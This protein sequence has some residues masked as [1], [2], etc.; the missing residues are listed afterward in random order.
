MSS[1][2]L[3]ATWG[4]VGGADV[5]QHYTEP[6]PGIDHFKTGRG[7]YTVPVRIGGLGRFPGP[8]VP[9]RCGLPLPCGMV[10]GSAPVRLRDADGR[11]T[12][13]QAEPAAYWHDGSI[14]WLLLDFIAR[15]PAHQAVVHPEPQ[16]T[17]DSPLRVEEDAET[18]TITT[19]PMKL[20][21]PRTRLALRVRSGST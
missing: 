11:D 1:P 7:C 6:G 20:V 19:G 5:P 17:P 10:R 12:P 2:E 9:V 18:I 21:V 3:S 4:E 16:K 14:R 8:G 15:G 13:A